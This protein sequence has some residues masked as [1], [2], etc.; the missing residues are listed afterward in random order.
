MTT[1][2][3]SVALRE[4]ERET[5]EQ[6]WAVD[7]YSKYSPGERYVPLFLDMS[8]ADRTASVLD[9]GCGGGQGALA[10]Q[11]AGFTDVRC[12]DLTDA[13]LVPDAR[14]FSFT[15]V[16]LWD[17]LLLQCVRPVDWVYCADVLEHIP[18][19]FTMLVVSQLLRIVNRGLFLSISMM[20]DDYGVW[21]GRTLHQ[22]VQTFPQWSE[23]LAAV[24]HVREARDLLHTGLFLVEPC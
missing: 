14:Q 17:D 22:T 2:A 1:G 4:H 19:P 7:A 11:S 10:L 9:A 15:T 24:G 18:T 5:Y 3:R 23:Q 20:P 6:I 21:I 13:G 8:G 12:C 16:C